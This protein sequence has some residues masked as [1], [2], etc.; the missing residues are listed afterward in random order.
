MP[1]DRGYALRDLLRYEHYWST[2]YE[3]ATIFLP[4][5]ANSRLDGGR[6][7]VPKAAQIL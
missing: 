1:V 4:G 7:E 3:C 6:N 5:D 2:H